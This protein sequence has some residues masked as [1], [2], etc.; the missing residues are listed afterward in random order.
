MGE[1][2]KEEATI[3]SRY[4]TNTD[5][6]VFGLINLPQVVAG[7]LFS[8]YSRSKKSARKILLEDFIQDPNMQ[9]E[10]IVGAQKEGAQSQFIATKRAEEF[11]ERVLVGFGDDSV[12]EL[13][14]AHVALEQIS[15]LAT[16]FIQDS[17]IG[18]SPL[19]KSTRYVYFDEKVDGKYKYYRGEELISSPA[20]EEYLKICDKLFDAYCDLQPKVIA[21][22]QKKYSKEE[23]VSERAYT[24]TIRAKTCD[25]LRGLLPASTLTNMGVYANGRAFEYLLTKMYASNLPEINSLASQAQSELSII[26][27]SFVKRAND[28]YGISMQEYMKD[29]RQKTSSLAKEKFLPQA[30]KDAQEVQ[31]VDY[32][33]D[34]EQKI[35]SAILFECGMDYEE[36]IK[37]ASQMQGGERKQL[38]D[39]YVGGRLNRRHKPGRAFEHP[40][41]TFAFCANFGQYRDLHRHRM[42][43]QARQLLSCDFGYDVPAEII[44]AGLDAEF[45]SALEDAKSAYEKINRQTNPFLAQYAVPMAYKLKWHMRMNLR[46]AFHFIELRSTPQGHEDYRRVTIKMLKEIEKVHPSLA[47]YIKFA[48]TKDVELERLEAEKNIDKKLERLNAEKK[49]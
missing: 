33:K 11:Y 47:N 6:N 2:S 24:S 44:A 37:K 17:R 38:L 41:Y 45:K 31:L 18:A 48:N 36:A 10:Q 16:K 46:E 49:Q 40:Y 3:L 26:I 14:G 22:L 1:F 8:R 43:T 28:K 30:Q 5:K 32:D 34:A 13:G 7:C 20:G 9:F 19:E 29:C 4:F 27:P 35:I 42:L 21:Y 12:A 15:I 39:A 25:L 23:N